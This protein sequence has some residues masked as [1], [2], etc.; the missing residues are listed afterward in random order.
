MLTGK[1]R[2]SRY[3]LFDDAADSD[4]VMDNSQLDD[5]YDDSNDVSILTIKNRKSR[6]S[7]LRRVVD[8]K[9]VPDDNQMKLSS[10]SS[11]LR[12]ALPVKKSNTLLDRDF[13]LDSEKMLNSTEDPFD[14]DDDDMSEQHSFEYE[15]SSDHQSQS[16]QEVEDFEE[17]DQVVSAQSESDESESQESSSSVSSESEDNN[18]SPLKL[19]NTSLGEPRKL[20]AMKASLFNSPKSS[21][22][23]LQQ[24]SPKVAV[25]PTK[26]PTPKPPQ[27]P[28]RRFGIEDPL[29]EM[30]TSDNEENEE[31]DIELSETYGSV[32]EE[33]L[34]AV[35]P[36]DLDQ[37]I[38][39]SK[40]YIPIDISF[41]ESIM[42]GKQKKTSAVDAGLWMGK[43]FR[44]GWG[45]DG[46]YFSIGSS[47]NLIS[48]SILTRKK[49]SILPTEPLFHETLL[50]TLLTHTNI[51]GDPPSP[52]PKSTLTF[53]ILPQTSLFALSAALFD[54]PPPTSPNE[55]AHRRE[56][57]S[58]WLKTNL[59][60]I[61][62]KATLFDLLATRNLGRAITQAI[63]QKPRLATI[64]AQ[65]GGPSSRLSRTTHGIPGLGGTDEKLR[66]F[67]TSHLKIVHNLPYPNEDI[68]VLQLVSGTGWDAKLWAKVGKTWPQVFALVFWYADGGWYSVEKAVESFEMLRKKG[69]V[70][71]ASDGA[72]M[73]LRL[74]ERKKN[75]EVLKLENV[76]AAQDDDVVAWI[77][78]VVLELKNIV[79]DYRTLVSHLVA[80]LISE[81]L[82]K[83][84]IFVAL[85]IKD[86]IVRK[87]V[88]KNILEKWY[89]LSDTNGSCWDDVVNEYGKK[90][91]VWDFLV[92]AL[93]IP[94]SWIHEAKALQARYKGDIFL[95]AICLI[96]ANQYVN[97][98]HLIMSRMVANVII[99]GTQNQIKRLLKQIPSNS[100]P[101][102]E[103]H[104]GAGLILEYVTM[105][106]EADKHNIT[107]TMS[108]S[109]RP[110]GILDGEWITRL[111]ALASALRGGESERLMQA[112]KYYGMKENV[113]VRVAVSIMR[114][115]VVT[116]LESSEAFAK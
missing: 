57:L 63:T 33:S 77:L 92:G 64:L 58:Q 53:A 42:F 91:S 74:F 71:C 113:A 93:K 35:E 55:N 9:S 67:I 15:E 31:I 100:I 49:V 103:Y 89:P 26:Q 34:F 56:A 44:V 23:F 28:S 101:Q 11:P 114:E 3:G 94:G 46:S 41:E 32:P 17:E 80:G 16:E 51:A 66:M 54:T 30:E 5:E 111:Q 85:W 8:W 29:Q 52:T 69:K 115:K 4:E 65:I 48:Q 60:P 109:K 106:E 108:P 22:S 47:K 98:H 116:I 40:R 13:L 99:S 88:I 76:F 20:Q 39:N 104:F 68:S 43:S 105:I 96:D 21:I 38:S 112:P 7:D 62:H 70:T 72:L 59:P 37:S 2:K 36:E 25:S 87:S 6:V 83:W 14:D 97:A 79:G 12:F 75:G 90:E 50:Q 102:A 19:I 18:N 86:E 61:P 84:A 95:E 45:P 107:P 81:G 24:N 1:R 73:V 78:G 82:W 27:T 10:R 110:R